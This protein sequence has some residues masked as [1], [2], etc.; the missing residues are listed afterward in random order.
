MPGP[1]A[2]RAFR[3]G[4]RIR[5]SSAT[6]RVV[7]C[8]RGVLPGFSGSAKL[9]QAGLQVL[10]RPLSRRCLRVLRRPPGAPGVCGSC[11]VSG[12]G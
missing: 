12:G 7:V 5:R 3:L 1:S 6:H 11:G 10:L 4:S 2:F 8:I 9:A